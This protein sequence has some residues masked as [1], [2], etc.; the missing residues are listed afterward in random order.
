MIRDTITNWIVWA[1]D[2]LGHSNVIAPVTVTAPPPPRS[3]NYQLPNNNSNLTYFN[4]GIKRDPNVF[5]LFNSKRGWIYWKDHTMTI[6]TAN[7]LRISLPFHVYPLRIQLLTF[8][9]LYKHMFS[10]YV[11]PTLTLIL[12]RTSH[13]VYERI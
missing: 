10:T 12:G 5:Q 3:S 2:D 4:R 8:S 6:I 13:A 1:E 11:L 7:I 9:V